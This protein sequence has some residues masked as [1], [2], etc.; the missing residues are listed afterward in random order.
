V[1]RRCRCRAVCAGSAGGRMQLQASRPR[2]QDCM[3]FACR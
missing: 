1:A 3:P 2:L